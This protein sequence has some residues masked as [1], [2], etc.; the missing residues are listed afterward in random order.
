MTHP[1]IQDSPV[2]KSPRHDDGSKV[3]PQS[4]FDFY[5]ACYDVSL[6]GKIRESRRL[7]VN[8]PE[9]MPFETDLFKGH[10]MVMHKPPGPDGTP[11]RYLEYLGPKRRRWEMRWQGQFKKDVPPDLRFGLEVDNDPPELGFAAR[12]LVRFL[13][14]VASRLAEARGSHLYCNYGNQRHSDYGATYFMFPLQSA[15]TVLEHDPN[16]PNIPEICT[17]DQLKG[18][19]PMGYKFRTDK[20]YTFC[21]YSMY[22]DFVTW[23]IR[24]V[25]G[26][27]GTCLKSM[28]GPQPFR[29]ALKDAATNEYY[30]NMLLAHRT[31]TREWAA[32]FESQDEIEM[33][34]E[35][36]VASFYS[37]LS[38]NES[39]RVSY[40]HTLS[41]PPTR[42]SIRSR[43][44]EWIFVPCLAS[45]RQLAEQSSRACQEMVMNSL[46]TSGVSKPATTRRRRRRR[47][48]ARLGQRC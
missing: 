47:H 21:Y 14:K 30:M 42:R 45:R 24:N 17:N 32:Y 16:D 29:I 33:Q 38:G 13:L 15:D 48:L 7:P 25:F 35:H 9:P 5:G 44:W 28:L 11:F 8:A 18:T 37:A 40:V 3:D 46:S 19:V 41:T 27:S 4:T 10:I 26:A 39:P 31:L 22:C 20:V 34:R 12:T 36:S 43:V 23:D 6:D 2:R 1:V